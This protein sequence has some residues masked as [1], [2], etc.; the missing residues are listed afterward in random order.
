M[1]P[2]AQNNKSVA[3]LIIACSIRTSEHVII[4]S[5]EVLI[6]QAS[7]LFR[8]H[9]SRCIRKP[10]ICI[11]LFVCS[12]LTLLSTLSVISRRCLVVTGSSM[13]T[14]IV[15]PHCGI[16]SQ[17]LLPDTT[18]S[19]IILTPEQPV[20]DLP[21]KSECHALRRCLVV[22]GSSMLTFIVLPHCGIRSQTLLPDTTSSHIILTPEQPVLALPRKSECHALRRC[23]VVTGSSMLTF[24]VLPHCGIRSQTLLPDTTSSH[25]ILTPEQPVLALPRKSECHALSN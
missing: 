18:S 2:Q 16:R 9:M 21:R 24:I 12:G 25:I 1:Q 22:T 8:Y 6:L 23:L 5:K 14:F 15:L 11:C 20:L 3:K 13:L 10:S 4:F 19:H 7:C 17:T